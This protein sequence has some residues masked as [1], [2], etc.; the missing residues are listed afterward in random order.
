MVQVMQDLGPKQRKYLITGD[1]SWIFW[2]DHHGGMWA[3]DQEEVPP[4]VKSIIYSKTTM[5]S[6]YLSRT[7]FISIEFL[8]QGQNYN[9]HFSTEIILPSIGAEKR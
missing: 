3:E 9:S 6:A 7:D 8:P 4:N 5:L 1:E 2:D